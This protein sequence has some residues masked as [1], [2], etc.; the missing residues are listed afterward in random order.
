MPDWTRQQLLVAFGLYCQLPF[1]KLHRGNPLIIEYAEKIGRSP[2]AL[3]LKL[4][5]IASLDPAITSTGRSGMKNAS[6]ADRAMWSEMNA[7]WES[8]ALASAEALSAVG[9][10]PTGEADA[11]SQ[12]DE[13]SDYTAEDTIAQTKVRTGQGFFRR[14]VLSAYDFQ[15]CITGL[16]VPSLLVASHIVPWRD[17]HANRLNPRNGL[18]L[19]A[20]HDR[21]FDAGIIT[22]TKQMTV[23]VSS[24]YALEKDQ[25]LHSALVGYEGSPIRLPEKFPPEPEFLDYHR[26]SIF[27]A[28]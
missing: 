5:N 17:D 15:C 26:T 9:I 4:T 22:I 18:C 28:D 16:S 1:G 12:V 8:F 7:D 27:K 24:A 14:T 3:A 20:L 11:D 21:A 25:F 23:R 2:S 13:L 10:E 19:S 6:A